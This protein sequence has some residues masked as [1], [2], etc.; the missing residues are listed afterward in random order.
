MQ[1]RPRFTKKNYLADLHDAEDAIFFASRE[2]RSWIWSSVHQNDWKESSWAEPC[3]GE[4]RV[5]V[6]IKSL[7]DRPREWMKSAAEF[8]LMLTVVYAPHPGRW[9]WA[10]SVSIASCFQ[11]YS[12]ASYVLFSSHLSMIINKFASPIHPVSTK[13]WIMVGYG[14]FCGYTLVITRKVGVK[15]DLPQSHFQDDTVAVWTWLLVIR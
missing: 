11:D 7:A 3:T 15:S 10:S 9:L 13:R 14:L 8:W 12:L 2:K 4:H 5:Q 1:K 6:R